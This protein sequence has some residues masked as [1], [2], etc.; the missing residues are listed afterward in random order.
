MIFKKLPIFCLIFLFL[1]LFL[2]IGFFRAKKK[3]NTNHRYNRGFRWTYSNIQFL[4]QPSK[5][6]YRKF[7]EDLEKLYIHFLKI[8]KII[9]AFPKYICKRKKCYIIYLRES[10]IIID[11][12]YC[13]KHRFFL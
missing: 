6:I 9:I 10:N 2:F 11:K 5:T 8:G 1:F 3:T 4:K 7:F 13:A 12:N